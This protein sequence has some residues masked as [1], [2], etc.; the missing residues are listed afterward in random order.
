MSLESYPRSSHIGTIHGEKSFDLIVRTSA[1]DP[2]VE[3]PTTH[4]M[5]PTRYRQINAVT[6]L[7]TVSE[8]GLAD[9]S[10]AT[11]RA[12]EVCIGA[13]LVPIEF[14]LRGAFLSFQTFLT[15]VFFLESDFAL[16]FWQTGDSFQGSELTTFVAKSARPPRP[17]RIDNRIFFG[18]LFWGISSIGRASGWQPEGQGFKSP[19]LHCIG[20]RLCQARRVGLKV[21]AGCDHVRLS[22]FSKALSCEPYFL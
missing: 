16:T 19:I 18:N 7:R 2:L 14:R 9:A 3:F 20:A 17:K 11:G 13:S 6:T 8:G 15:S 10:T 1:E 5:R 21:I 4:S 12:E 22:I